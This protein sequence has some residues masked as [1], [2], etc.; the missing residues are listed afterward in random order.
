[1]IFKDYVNYFKNLTETHPLTLHKDVVGSKIFRLISAEEA[2]GDFRSGIKEKSYLVRLLMPSLASKGVDNF[3]RFEW[4]C[5]FLVAKYTPMR[6]T[7]ADDSMIDALDETQAVASDF[8]AQIIEDSING[9]H[10]FAYSANSPEAIHATMQPRIFQG[11]TQYSGWLVTFRLSIPFTR[12]VPDEGYWTSQGAG[13]WDA[14]N[15]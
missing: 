15:L 7:D 8:L 6:Q 10:L 2:V 3:G 4:L 1:M 9:H 11:D 13:F 14:P 5:G 12:C